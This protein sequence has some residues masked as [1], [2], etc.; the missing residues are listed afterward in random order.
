LVG[1]VAEGLQVGRLDLGECLL[2]GRPR[3]CRGA[4][5]RSGGSRRRRFVLRELIL[6]VGA[7]ADLKGAGEAGV[8]LEALLELAVE[9]AGR[10]LDDIEDE[11]AVLADAAALEDAAGAGR[12]LRLGDLL[13]RD[14]PADE[15]LALAPLGEEGEAHRLAAARR[16]EGAREVLVDG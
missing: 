4:G 5:G 13:R 6:G 3:A 16:L 10:L 1:L 14:L 9:R 11:G 12:L 15:Q 2:P 8:F 7:D